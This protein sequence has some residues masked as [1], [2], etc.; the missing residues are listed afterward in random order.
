MY[1]A[2]IIDPTRNVMRNGILPHVSILRSAA[3]VI[4]KSE[5]RGS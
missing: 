1:A 4:A 5:H 2:V 3:P